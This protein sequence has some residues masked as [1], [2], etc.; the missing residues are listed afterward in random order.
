M[1]FVSLRTVRR[2]MEEYNLLSRTFTSIT[3]EELASVVSRIQADFPNSGYRMMMGHLR[4]N[5]LNI[6]R[7]RLID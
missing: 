1:P 4:A 5:G 7:H 3:D 6:Q 2:R